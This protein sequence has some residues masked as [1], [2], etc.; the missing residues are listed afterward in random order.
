MEKWD[1]SLFLIIA[2]IFWFAHF[3]YIPMLSPYIEQLGGTF[4]FTGIVLASYGLMQL[5]F[6]VPIGIGSDLLKNRKIF[7]VLGIAISTSSCLAFALTAS[8]EWILISRALAGI[9]AAT[10]VAF[11]IL[12]SNYVA[13][14]KLHSAMGNLSFALVFA[15]MLGMAFSA[16]LVETLG[17]SAPYW[18][19]TILG[20]IGLLLSFLISEGNKVTDNKP[21]K[22]H[23]LGKVV[24]EP[25][26]LKVSLLSIFAHSII[27]T[28][29][30]GFTTA[31]AL[32]KGLRPAEISLVVFAFMIPHAIATLMS[33]KPFVLEIGK[34]RIVQLA[35]LTTGIFTMIMA[36]IET[37]IMFFF[38]QM[39]NG[40]ALGLLFPLFLGMAVEEIPHAKRATA[41]G[42]Y[43]AIYAIGMFVG[44]FLA[45]LLNTS[46]GLEASF[47]FSGCIGIVGFICSLLWSR[48]VKPKTVD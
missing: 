41:M 31:Y 43:Q 47:Y 37:K 4:T 29:M 20:S 22:L 3:L 1:Q 32:S 9:A 5:L 46:F 45:G 19:G 35:F 16:W 14:D 13:D 24:K 39:I 8:L 48:K 12:F 33:G 44:P 38:L 23:E 36:Q 11:T 40:F 27:F 25:M 18:I 6:R 17:W 26:L 30:F 21:I 34:W 7:V 15:Q 42:A 28:T 2:F 10:W